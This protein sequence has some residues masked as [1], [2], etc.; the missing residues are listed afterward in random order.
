M[1]VSGIGSV[2]FR[3]QVDSP[4]PLV[5]GNWAY[6]VKPEA[7]QNVPQQKSGGGFWKKALLWTAAVAAVAGALVYAKNTESVKTV[8]DKAGSF[9]AAETIADKCKYIIG[10]GGQYVQSAW[11]ATGGKLVGMIFKK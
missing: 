11:D 9:K 7:Q 8:L 4:S 6:L 1:N 10:K 5:S 2:P 3:A